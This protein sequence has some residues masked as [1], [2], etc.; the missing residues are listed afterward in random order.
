MENRTLG[1]LVISFLVILVLGTIIYVYIGSNS[2]DNESNTPSIIVAIAPNGTYEYYA[3]DSSLSTEKTKSIIKN[4]LNTKEKG[5]NGTIYGE[6]VTVK[7][8]VINNYT[9][10]MGYFQDKN[11]NYNESTLTSIA[12]FE[13]QVA[14]SKSSKALYNYRVSQGT[15]TNEEAQKEIQDTKERLLKENEYGVIVYWNPT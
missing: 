15:M 7:S 9:V 4:A 2:D 10:T 13:Y 1:F 6:K 12:N 8:V 11:Y 5:V 14:I 3:T